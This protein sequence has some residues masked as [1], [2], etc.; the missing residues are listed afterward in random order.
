MKIY[1]MK[2]KA[3]DFIKSNIGTLY[4]NYYREKT[5]QW[6]YDLFD[7]DPFEL[8]K[9]VPDI[10]LAS[11]EN[12]KGEV[13][14]ENCKI[15]YK[16]LLN[17]SASQASDERLWAGLCNGVFYDYLIKRWN[18]NNL[19]LK[20]PKKDASTVLSRFFFSGGTRAGF[21]RNSLAKYWWVGQATYQHNSTD[22]FEL[23]DALGPED[24]VSKISDLFYSNTFASNPVILR[25]ICKAWQLLKTKGLKLT[26]R[27][28]FRP[29]LQYL[30]AV[31]GGMLLDI[32]SEDEVKRLFFT[33]AYQLYNNESVAIIDEEIDELD[34]E[35]S[36]IELNDNIRNIKSK[37]EVVTITEITSDKPSEAVVIGD[38]SSNQKKESA[39]LQ[40]VMGVPDKVVFGC[41]VTVK[42]KRDNKVLVYNIPENEK[43][44]WYPIQR[45]LLNK[46]VNETVRCAPDEYVIMDIK[47]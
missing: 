4:I 33:Y 35:E 37:N 26:V 11:L 13:D 21:F 47:W 14:L 20:D 22:K 44:Q 29:T 15:M 17:I 45:M 10:K 12:K 38:K 28:H 16:S 19:E 36:V 23:L 40:S 6:I 2:Q 25:G 30:N 32:L 43:G 3:L 8:F 42:R 9:D 41:T 24:F 31:G 18:Y 39:M 34:F 1:F 46:S 5:N 7:Y 27:E